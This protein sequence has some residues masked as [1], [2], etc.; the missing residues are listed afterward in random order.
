MLRIRLR[1]VGRKHD[2]HYQIVVAPKTNAVKSNYTCKLG[3]FDSRSKELQ[4]DE[5]ELIKW[6]DKGAVP[7]NTVAKLLIGK[8]IKHNLISYT[9][10]NPSKPKKEDKQKIDKS[11]ADKTDETKNTDQPE[12]KADSEVAET[13]TEVSNSENINQETKKEEVS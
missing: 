11:P 13:P 9:P 6:L 12:K 7:T 2:P 10:M 3:W 1:R 8:K 4:I 5:I